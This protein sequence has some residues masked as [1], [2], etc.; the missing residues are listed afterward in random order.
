M[1]R[2]AERGRLH[3]LDLDEVVSAA[4]GP[5]LRVATVARARGA[6][7]VREQGHAVGREPAAPV[8][9]GEVGLLRASVVALPDPDR[10]VVD[11]GGVEPKQPLAQDGLA[12]AGRERDVALALEEDGP[13]PLLEAG[14]HRHQLLR[15]EVRRE[16]AHA[17]ADVA[18]HGGGDHEPARVDDR[19]H[20]DARAPVEVGRE[21]HLRD[22][23]GG[24]AEE[25]RGRAGALAAP[26]VVERVLEREQLQ[27]LLHGIARGLDRQQ[28]WRARHALRP[29]GPSSGAP[30]ARQ[31]PRSGRRPRRSEPW[32]P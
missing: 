16:E 2:G 17:A 22:P 4:H 9:A 7:V 29:R 21:H 14:A 28:P 15:T 26:E 30:P 25:R 18:A 12:L 6:D 13:E 20:G 8:H 31:R 27:E 11:A 1:R 19:A 32:D 10:T 24:V 23:P 3:R 5:D